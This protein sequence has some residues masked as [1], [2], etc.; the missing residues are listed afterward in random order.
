MKANSFTLFYCL[1]YKKLV[2]SLQRK[3]RDASVNRRLVVSRILLV[4]GVLLVILGFLHLLATPLI[5]KWLARELT[6]EVLT[7]V[8]P[9]F[10]LNHLVVGVLL[11]PFGVSTL[12][13]AA[14]VRA[15]QLWARGI[16]MTNSL[17]V[18]VMPLLVVILLGKEYFSSAPFLAAAIL[19]T[20]I[21]VSMFLP[22]LWLQAGKIKSY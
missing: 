16:A 22:L 17:A 9:P 5:N 12:Y 19:I 21:G 4:D 2:F 15:G 13:S 11:I 10:L 8:S 20:C 6:K 14:G 7:A 1:I 18:L 3:G